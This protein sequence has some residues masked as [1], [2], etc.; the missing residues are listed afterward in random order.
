LVS[1]LSLQFD[2]RRPLAIVCRWGVMRRRCHDP[3][4][5]MDGCGSWAELFLFWCYQPQPQSPPS[6]PPESSAVGFFLRVGPTDCGTLRLLVC[7]GTQRVEK[8]VCGCAACGDFEA[9]RTM[10]QVMVVVA[11]DHEQDERCWTMCS[12]GGGLGGDQRAIHSRR[13]HRHHRHRRHH[14][15][16]TRERFVTSLGGGVATRAALHVDGFQSTPD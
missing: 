7:S 2:G 3:R 11:R 6:A 4:L 16:R 14:R 1:R 5:R 13:R 8:C 10:M 15:R 9:A 12:A